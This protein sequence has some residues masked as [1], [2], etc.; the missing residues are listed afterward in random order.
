MGRPNTDPHTE[1]RLQPSRARRGLQCSDVHAEC[2]GQFR[3]RQELV[4]SGVRGERLA[5]L[6]D[7]MHGR[8]S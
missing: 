2:L 4:L 8:T 7:D 5:S 3:Q 1:L 6:S